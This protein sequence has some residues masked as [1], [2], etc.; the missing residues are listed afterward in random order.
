MGRKL[1]PD[2]YISTVYDVD[3]SV[4][5]QEGYSAILFD[6]DNTLVPHDAPAD[7]RAISFFKYLRE[8]G[9]KTATISNNS[10]PR[11]KIFCEAVGADTYIYK[12][13]KPKP[14]AYIE[15]MERL[16]SDRSNTL[17]IGDQLFTDIAGANAAGVRSI[18]VKPI[19]KWK[20]TKFIRF[21]RVF[22]G[23]LMGFYNISHRNGGARPVPLKGR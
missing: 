23:I 1:F 20:E 7:E 14:D 3:F 16:S 13:K 12:A 2:D 21:K 11:V 18:M 8:L 4:L 19:L 10:E 6:V 15:G 22:E 5:A 17:F 9:Y